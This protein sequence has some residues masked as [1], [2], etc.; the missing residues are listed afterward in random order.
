MWCFCQFYTTFFLEGYFLE[1]GA[2]QTTFLTIKI[3]S[4]GQQVNEW[5]PERFNKSDMSDG[6]A[7]SDRSEG[8]AW[9]CN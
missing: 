9:V 1:L 4:T 5:V 8:S 2:Y 7:W 6:S 3:K